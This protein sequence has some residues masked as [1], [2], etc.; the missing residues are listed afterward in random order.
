VPFPAL[1]SDAVTTVTNAAAT[2][3]PAVTIPSG[4][5]GELLLVFVA[6]DGAPTIAFPAGYTTLQAATTDGASQV[7]TAAAYRVT[8]GSEGATLTVTLGTAKAMSALAV[9]M[10]QF[11]GTPEAATPATGASTTSDPPNFAPSWGAANT[12][13]LWFTGLD[14]NL[15]GPNSA[16]F[17]QRGELLI[18]DRTANTVNDVYAYAGITW[19]TAASLNP[20]AISLTGSE[21]WVA[22]TY[23]LKGG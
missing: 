22:N 19:S 21:Q 20:V 12:A 1:R 14:Q 13:F 17:A 16:S 9:R 8:D 7:S 15:G 2:T 4:D 18:G 5:V 23:A 11:T 3:T 6:T 10:G